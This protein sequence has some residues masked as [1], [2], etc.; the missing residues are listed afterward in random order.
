M[1][2]VIRSTV[3]SLTIDTD[4][5]DAFQEAVEAGEQLRETYN[6][7]QIGQKDTHYQLI[8][9]TDPN[10]EHRFAVLAEEPAECDWQDTDTFDE[11]LDLYEETVRATAAGMGDDYEEYEDE[12]TGEWVVGDR[13]QP[14]KFTD[15]PGIHGYED[16]AEEVGNA[17]GRMLEAQWA[18]EAAEA[19]QRIAAEKTEARQIAYARAVD[20]FGR[21]GNAVLAR[22]VGLSEPTVKAIADK[23][24]QLLAQRREDAS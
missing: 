17:Q 2:R 4:Q 6:T 11:A 14:F 16:K 22:Q 12:E 8:A 7:D 3:Q 21:G 15:V 13:K 19:A 24:R 9:Y 18:T 1:L 5:E 20:E 10:G 23:G